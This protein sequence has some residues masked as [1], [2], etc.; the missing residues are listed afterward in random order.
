MKSWICNNRR[1]LVPQ[2]APN[3]RRWWDGTRRCHRTGLPAS[4][5]GKPG[6]SPHPWLGPR[7]KEERGETSAV[8]RRF[9]RTALPG[10][11]PSAQPR[12]PSKRC[13]LTPKEPAPAR[14]RPP[15]AQPPAVKPHLKPTL[16]LPR[17]TRHW[18]LPA[19]G[20][21][22]PQQRCQGHV[23]PVPSAARPAPRPEPLLPAGAQPGVPKQYT[24]ILNTP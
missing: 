16:L 12:A 19:P 15:P 21:L 1:N 2:T 24:I 5:P 20:L 14:R 4:E 3:T 18:Q 6:S 9:P 23:A 13:L 22:P 8:R 11:H 10:E 17:P 7:G